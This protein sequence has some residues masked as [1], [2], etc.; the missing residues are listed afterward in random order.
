[1]T[2]PL[3]QVLP[4]YERAFAQCSVQD[5]VKS[6]VTVV[7]DRMVQ[8]RSHYET[9]EK[10]TGIPWWF[11]GILHYKEWNQQQPERFTQHVTEV[12]LAK[13]YHKAKTRTLESYLWGLDLWNGFKD[14]VGESSTWLWMGTTVGNP[15]PESS[16]S[17]SS[18]NI[19]AAALVRYL[20]DEGMIDMP[21][22][23]AGTQ[24]V[25]GAN[26]IFKAKLMQS[27]VLSPT[28]KVSVKA[29]TRLAILADEPVAD[30]HVK[31]V[32][33]DG[34][35]L[36]QEDRLEWYVY[37]GHIKIVGTEHDNKPRDSVEAPQVAIASVDKGDPITLPKLGT[38]YLGE[39]I[40]DG[41]HFSWAEATKNG[42]RIPV[43][44][45][46]V[47][48]ILKI[49]QVMEE[50]RELVDNRS[51]IVTSWYRDPVSNKTVGGASRSRHLVGDAVDF[52]VDG[53]APSN[54][55]QLLEPWWGDRGG[56]ASASSFTHIDA[57]GYKARWSYGF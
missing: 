20:S 14:G 11:A 4:E 31:V 57:R 56:I 5:A 16:T 10:V 29:G 27:A 8:L 53:M 25:V 47:D 45:T 42:T 34:V 3:S 39:A 24:L 40:M 7:A 22:A 19:G 17:D 51:I 21:S 26:T 46:V 15:S 48:N 9:V 50:V 44:A 33:P 43:D 18:A 13:N 52:I 37:K 41:G 36:G 54:V 55:H 30:D 6:T 28:D 49:A 12:L 23:Q 1:M 35:L 2:Y 32:L 38:V